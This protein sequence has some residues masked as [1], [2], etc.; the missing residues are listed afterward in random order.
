MI[1]LIVVIGARGCSRCEA[2][3]RIL[4]QKKIEYKYLLYD[5]MTDE[6]Q[7]MYLEKAK[8]A[9]MMNFPLIIKNDQLIDV[10]DV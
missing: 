8:E 10:K 6:S 5:D 3:K 4:N 9:G 2:I 7:N 1:K